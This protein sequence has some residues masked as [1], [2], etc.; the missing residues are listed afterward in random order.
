MTP[1]PALLTPERRAEIRH[2]LPGGYPPPW[3]VEP[4]YQDDARTVLRGW[5]VTRADVDFSEPGSAPVLMA[6]DYGEA[7]A[8]WAAHARQ[9]LPDLLDETERLYKLIG[10]VRAQGRE[11]SQS[12]DLQ[13]AAAGRIL[14]ALVDGRQ[15]ALIG[16]E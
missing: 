7:F 11:W 14:L 9:D 5:V 16:I 3:Q 1:T 15:G 8:Q 6:P 12:R 2:R 13:M 10:H 4:W